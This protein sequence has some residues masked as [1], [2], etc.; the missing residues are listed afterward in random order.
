MT[1]PCLSPALSFVETWA[2]FHSA[3]SPDIR[4]PPLVH[5][6]NAGQ[7]WTSEVPRPQAALGHPSQY[8]ALSGADTEVACTSPDLALP[9]V[10]HGGERSTV[11]WRRQTPGPCPLQ[12]SGAALWVCL[13]TSDG[14]ASRPLAGPWATRRPRWRTLSLQMVSVRTACA[15][16]TER[17]AKGP[18]AVWG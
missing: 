1:L 4:A 11:T 9:R 12:V 7:P 10:P 17:M 3:F 2:P 5:Q 14:L 16:S 6:G 15:G 8:L 18:H 13:E